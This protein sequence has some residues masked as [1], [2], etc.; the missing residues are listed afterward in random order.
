MKTDATPKKILI[1]EDDLRIA[2]LLTRGLT[3]KGFETEVSYTGTLGLRRA[4]A[5]GFDLVILDI[6]LPE[7]SGYEVCQRIREQKPSLPIVM[8]TA[9]SEI[10]DKIEGFEAGADDYLV[11]PFDFREL[12][13]RVLVGLRRNHSEAQAVGKVLRIADL[14]IFLDSKLVKRAAQEINLTAREYEF[15][16]YLVKNKG[17][18]V[19]KNDIAANVWD[20]HFDTGTNVI[21]V[22]INILRRKIDRNFEPKLIHTRPG[23]G[24]LL[25]ET[26]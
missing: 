5:V 17:K 22:Y 12:Y 18:V 7:L 20:V 1:I 16:V 14:E 10:E 11:K 8:L 15:L 26:P 23:L 9:M 4:L 25:R 19:S 6:N 3:N 21:E 13:H 24:Y 2:Q